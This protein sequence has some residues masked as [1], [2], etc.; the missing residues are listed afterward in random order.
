MVAA[1]KLILTL[2]SDQILQSPQIKNSIV[3]KTNPS[4]FALNLTFSA[5]ATAAWNV[6]FPD[7]TAND[8]I[9]YA[10]LAQTLTNKTLGGGTVLPDQT[11]YAHLAGQAGGQTLNGG[12]AASENLTLSS[13]AN[14]TKGNVQVSDPL[15]MA[16]GKNITLQGAGAINLGTGNITLSGGELLGLP[17]TPSGN[18]AAT[19]K[20]YVDSQIALA[21]SGGV[22]W[23]ETLLSVD[24]LDNTNKAIA[25]A[26]A[27]YYSAQPVPGDTFI[28]KDGSTTETFTATAGAPGAFQFQIGGTVVNTMTNLAAS[29]TSNSTKWAAVLH[30][31]LQSINVTG[32]VIIVKRKVPTASP[33][34]RIYGVMGTPT[35]GKYVNYGGLLD[36]R[37]SVNAT[38]PAVDPGTANFG[39]GRITAGL[40][41][42][43]VHIVR[44]EDSIYEWNDDAGVWQL[45]GAATVLATSGPGGGVIGQA[46]YDSSLGLNVSAGVVNVKVDNTSVS[47]NGSGQLQVAGG[48]VP[49]GTSANNGVTGGATAGK[50]AGDELQGVHILGDGTVRV[51][52][53]GSTMGFDGSGN[54]RSTPVAQVPTGLVSQNVLFTSNIPAV[55]APTP[56]AI[57]SD[58]PTLDYP[59]GSTTGQLFDINV[60]DDYDSGNME[61]LAVYQMSGAGGNVRYQTQAKIVKISGSIDT[62]TY[63]STGVTLTSPSA[64]P[65]RA[66]LMT[67]TAGTFAKGDVIQVYIS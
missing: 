23:R 67:L 19:S 65:S 9:V 53:D 26:V 45:S 11:Q 41:P 33:V 18:T 25:Q 66:V 30:T 2:Q 40:S 35:N 8:A 55:T 32:N 20:F 58:I 64:N 5:P 63:P 14:V 29:I 28:I 27:F 15:L 17:N 38:L 3:L 34:D 22:A 31:N 7:P 12:T 42:S 61:I 52:V 16:S 44:A 50:V 1:T 37:S 48:A 46:T 10:N 13:T 62:A 59:D 39:L 51:K 57:S 36:Y 21:V 6:N 60:P 4:D 43:E 47:F 56:G 54:L 49:L 24:Q